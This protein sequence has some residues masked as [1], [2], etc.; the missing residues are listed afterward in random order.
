M[1]KAQGDREVDESARPPRL[2]DAYNYPTPTTSAAEQDGSFAGMAVEDDLTEAELTTLLEQ[3]RIAA[4]DEVQV[5]V[6]VNRPWQGPTGSGH[7][8][9]LAARRKP[10]A[11]ASH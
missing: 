7:R 1:R 8:I 11:T 3:A 4:A 2:S 6:R 5:R 10:V 9:R